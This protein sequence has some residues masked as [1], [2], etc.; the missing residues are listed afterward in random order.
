M[1]AIWSLPAAT[2]VPREASTAGK[3]FRLAINHLRRL[4]PRTCCNQ[5]NDD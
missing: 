5:A 4:K 3:R 2:S 1:V